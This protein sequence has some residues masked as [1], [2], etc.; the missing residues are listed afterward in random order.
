MITVSSDINSDGLRTCKCI[1]GTSDYQDSTTDEIC[2]V[3]QEPGNNIKYVDLYG[4]FL[5]ILYYI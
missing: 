1:K 3:Q 2:S 4:P 5:L